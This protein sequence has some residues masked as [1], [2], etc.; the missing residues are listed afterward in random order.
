MK[1]TGE[2]E[3]AGVREMEEGRREEGGRGG[4]EE[5]GREEGREEGREATE[6]KMKKKEWTPAESERSI[7][8]PYQL[9][10]ERHR[11]T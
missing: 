8:S 1:K 6:E 5:G 9:F 4:R 3:S 11:A 7:R 10:Q 2:G